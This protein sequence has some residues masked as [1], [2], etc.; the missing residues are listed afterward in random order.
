MEHEQAFVTVVRP[1]M[2]TTFQDAG[3]PG[4]A[5]LGVPRSGALDPKSYHLANRLVGNQVGAAV[6]ETTFDGVS[7]SFSSGA[8]VAVTGALADVSVNDQTVSWS[9]PVYVPPGGRLNVGTAAVGLRNYVAV[10]G[11]FQVTPVLSSRSRDLLSGLGPPPLVANQLIKI[12]PCPPS[13]P[14]VDFAPYLPL[15][16]Y[17]KVEVHPGPRREYLTRAA[18]HALFGQTYQVLPE[19][20]RIA[21]RLKGNPIDRDSNE[22]LASEAVVWGAL[23]LLPTGDIVVFL[24]DHPTTGGYPVIGVV[25]E[26]SA[27]LCAQLRSGDEVNLV[28]AR[29]WRTREGQI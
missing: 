13:M 27:S 18:E 15:G 25:D 20:N 23:E 19:S 28:R 5:H 17:L 24:A 9:M 12:G 8:L 3:R 1:G 26:A 2:L 7:L 14:A 29:S 6:L 11:G 22:E 4:F 10:A 21:L 16:D